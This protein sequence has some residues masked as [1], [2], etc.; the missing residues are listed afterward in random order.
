[1]PK[2]ETLNCRVIIEML[3]APKEHIEETIR[4]YVEQMKKEY[5]TVKVL[6]EEYADARKKDKLYSTFAELD[7]EVKGA[8]NLINFCFDYMPSSV[9]IFEPDI[10]TYDSHDFTDFLNDL[11]AKLHK[12]DMALKN[13]SAENQIM[14]KNTTALMRNLI[15]LILKSGPMKMEDIAKEAGIKPEAA[16]KALVL[17]LQ[18]KTVKFSDNQYQL[19]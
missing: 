5:K 17:M 16:D 2:E 10:L 6:R 11:Q 1:M 3:G 12:I 14:K 9:E 7:L 15:K 13:I 18:D 4:A 8:E 19:A